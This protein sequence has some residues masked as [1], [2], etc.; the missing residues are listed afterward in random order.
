MPINISKKRT[1]FG[2]NIVIVLP[3]ILLSALGV[4]TL[5][6]TRILPDGSLGELSIVWKQVIALG[7]GWLGFR[8]EERRVGK[9]C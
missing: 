9:E 1:F 5:L 8:S 3:L 2:S 4:I 7:I 6:S